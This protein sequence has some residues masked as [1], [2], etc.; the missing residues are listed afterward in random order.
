MDFFTTPILDYNL[1]L[2]GF[3]KNSTYELLN[4]SGV[5]VFSDAVDT[6]K[7][8]T[9]LKVNTNNSISW[10]NSGTN[11]YDFVI[12]NI[13]RKKEGY[14]VKMEFNGSSLGI[15]KKIEQSLSASISL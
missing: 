14:S 12:G 5:V 11:V 3:N 6:A 1:N 13:K 8:A 9:L 2:K 4:L 10:I 15:D 7:L